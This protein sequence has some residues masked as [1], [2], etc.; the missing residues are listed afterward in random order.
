MTHRR[1]L[2]RIAAAVSLAA[3]AAVTA[4]TATGSAPAP[5]TRADSVWRITVP[6]EPLPEPVPEHVTLSAAVQDSVW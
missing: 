1:P 5:E 3:A 4:L 6:A 2:L